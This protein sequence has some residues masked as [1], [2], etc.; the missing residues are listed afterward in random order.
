MAERLSAPLLLLLLLTL[1]A[2]LRAQLPLEGCIDRA[3]R[4]VRGIVR[5]DMSWTAQQSASCSHRA[6]FVFQTWPSMW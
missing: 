5:N 1:P 3:D 4:P 2:A 6:S